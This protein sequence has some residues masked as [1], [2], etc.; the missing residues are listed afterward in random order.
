MIIITIIITRK[1]ILR[2]F[3]IAGNAGGEQYNHVLL[4]VLLHVV[5]GERYNDDEN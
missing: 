4:D 5:G 3:D 1:K 2:V